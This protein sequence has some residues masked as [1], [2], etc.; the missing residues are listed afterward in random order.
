MTRKDSRLGE[1]AQVKSDTCW[2][3]EVEK[4]FDGVGPHPNI[5]GKL[6]VLGNII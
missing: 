4:R 5:A 3:A 1:G 6:G 2:K